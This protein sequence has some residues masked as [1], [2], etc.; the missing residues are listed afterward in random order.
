M[1]TVSFKADFDLIE[2]LDWYA[3]K[4]RIP[5]SL[6]IRKAIERMVKEEMSKETVPVVEKD[7]K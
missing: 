3:M 7:A 6:A 5:R 4:Y 1:R 2:V